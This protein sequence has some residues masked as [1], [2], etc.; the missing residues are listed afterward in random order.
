MSAMKLS[1]A[2]PARDAAILA[3]FPEGTCQEV[4]IWVGDAAQW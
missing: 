4:N 3:V 1:D 2:A